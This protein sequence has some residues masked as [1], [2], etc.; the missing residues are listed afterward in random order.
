MQSSNARGVK[1]RNKQQMKQCKH[2]KKISNNQNVKLADFTSKRDV[3]SFLLALLHSSWNICRNYPATFL[4][5]GYFPFL[6]EMKMLTHFKFV[7]LHRLIQNQDLQQFLGLTNA[8]YT[9]EG[10]RRQSISHRSFPILHPSKPA[11]HKRTQTHAHT[12]K[13]IILKVRGSVSGWVTRSWV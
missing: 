4:T 3:F 2:C 5:E 9:S 10:L 6:Q 11:Q 7:F 8:R 1:S 12:C 13:E